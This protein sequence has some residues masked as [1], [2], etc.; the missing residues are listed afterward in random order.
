MRASENGWESDRKGRTSTF[1]PFCESILDPNHLDIVMSPAP[2]LTNHPKLNSQ[3]QPAHRQITWLHCTDSKLSISSGW[4]CRYRPGRIPHHHSYHRAGGGERNTENKSRWGWWTG[5]VQSL[6]FPTLTQG[7]AQLSW[8]R[9]EEHFCVGRWIKLTLRFCS[10]SGF[11]FAPFLLK[12]GFLTYFVV[13][14][15]SS[16]PSL[17]YYSAVWSF[18]HKAE[19][20]NLP[21]LPSICTQDQARVTL[22]LLV[23]PCPVWLEKEERIF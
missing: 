7:R 21:E 18:C 3:P 22:G 4:Y 1:F 10:E 16:S 11:S 6:F 2:E 23:M 8:L 17:L 20:F 15:L 14:L 12:A 5:Q 13:L 19:I 9:A